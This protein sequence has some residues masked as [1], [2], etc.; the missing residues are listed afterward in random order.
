MSADSYFI[1]TGPRTFRPTQ[2]AVGAWSAEDHHFSPL[3]GLMVHVLE[4]ARGDSPLQLGRISFDILGRIAF[5][6]VEITVDVIRPG[7]TIELVEVTLTIA[8]RSVIRARAWYLL[9]S[10]ISS[11]EATHLS[12]LDAPEKCPPRNILDIWGGGFMEQLEARQAAPAE[13]GRGATW[14]T[15]PTIL[16]HGEEQIPVAE[17]CALIDTANGLA[18]R[19]DPREWAFPNVDLT[20]HFF[21]LPEGRWAGMD[22]SVDWG[23][24]GMGITSSVLHDIHGPVG[25]AS[26]CVTIRQP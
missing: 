8:G 9:A 2:H 13:P 4:Q 24:T 23:A 7:R 20:V 6:E 5:T 11:E 3:A 21:R 25:R 18:V 10:D 16:V 12:T 14:L 15:S 19:K 26:Q 22:I 1:R 17:Y